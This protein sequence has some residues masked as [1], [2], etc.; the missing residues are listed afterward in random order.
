MKTVRKNLMDNIKRV[1]LAQ[2]SDVDEALF[3]AGSADD[4]KDEGNYGEQSTEE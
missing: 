3:Q 4:M 2:T 1:S